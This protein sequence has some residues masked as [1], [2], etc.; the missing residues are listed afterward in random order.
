VLKDK[1]EPLTHLLA[2]GAGMLR[3]LDPRER[4]P[5][6]ILLSI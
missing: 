3:S 4:K 5:R 1:G 2:G 6:L